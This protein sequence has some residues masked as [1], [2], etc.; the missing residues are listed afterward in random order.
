MAR[1]E[2]KRNAYLV[3]KITG[4]NSQNS[5]MKPTSSDNVKVGDKVIVRS[6]EDNPLM[7]GT[8]VRF[9]SFGQ[10]NTRLPIIEDQDEK[11]WLCM[12]IIKLYSE[13]LLAEL[14]PMTPK[15]QWNHLSHHYKRV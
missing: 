13:E 14:E 3:D 15:E 9:E 4:A 1:N 12:G 5:R 6:N 11:E 7:I 2:T 8:L 10:S